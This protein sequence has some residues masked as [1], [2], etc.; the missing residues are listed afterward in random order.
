[1]GVNET[2]K[3]TKMVFTI[4]PENYLLIQKALCVREFCLNLHKLFRVVQIAP[5]Y[6]ELFLFNPYEATAQI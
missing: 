6:K 5:T 4:M 1:M 3:A 2:K